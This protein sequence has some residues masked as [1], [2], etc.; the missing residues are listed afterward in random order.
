SAVEPA[1][2]HANVQLITNAYVSR[3]ETSASGREVAGVVVER[4]GETQRFTAD[5]VVVSA[6]AINSAALLLR[7]ANDKHPRGLGN[8]SD[9]VGRNYMGHTNSV[10]L[11]LSREANP[12]IFQKTLGLNDFYFKSKEWEYP[13]G[14]ISFV[15]KLDA[16]SL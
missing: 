2:R 8:S 14:N 9:V 3:L 10:V 16:V 5:V 15:G 6:G 13:M 7:S 1:L 4:R 12:T 11:A